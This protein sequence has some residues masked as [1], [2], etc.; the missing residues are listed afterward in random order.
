[1]LNC[2][3]SHAIAKPYTFFNQQNHGI[4]LEGQGRISPY[5]NNLS[6]NV[7]TNNGNTGIFI[8][9]ACPDFGPGATCAAEPIRDN[10][11]RGN[12]VNRNGFGYPTGLPDRRIF[13]GPD[14]GGSGIIMMIGG[15][16]P[17]IRQT[18]IGN[19]ANENARHGIS[20]LPHRPGNPVT[21]SR[22]FG[23]TAV[24][25]NQLP[26]GPPSFNGQDGNADVNP[27]APCD[28]NVW[29]ANYFGSSRADIGGP[30]PPNNLTNHPCVG[31]RL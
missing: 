27:A 23:N 19:T 2:G 12:Q 8:P 4:R 15:P 1:M 11:V 28:N 25:N 6:G 14:N 18:V 22:I 13:E 7:V 24:R 26:G 16:N 5:E 29:A 9:S 20:V 3:P 30:V 17:P 21:M 10:L 31:P